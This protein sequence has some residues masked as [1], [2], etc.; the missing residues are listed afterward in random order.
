MRGLTEEELTFLSRTLA[1]ENDEY[2]MKKPPSPSYDWQ[3]AA[4][5]YE[6]G[7]IGEVVQCEDCWRRPITPLGR[8]ALR[9]HEAVSEMLVAA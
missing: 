2:R 7:C 3:T 8:L 4:D 5:L 1:N 6:R 9:V